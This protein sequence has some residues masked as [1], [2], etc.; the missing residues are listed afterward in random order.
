MARKFMELPP[1]KPGY[2]WVNVSL[3]GEDPVWEAQVAPIETGG[4]L[5]GYDEADFMAK[6]YKRKAA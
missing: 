2:W 1:L 4:K 3:P 6:Q 5:F